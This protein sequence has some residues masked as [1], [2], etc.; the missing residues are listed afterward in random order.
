MPDTAIPALPAFDSTWA[1]FSD[2]YR[3]I[4]RQCRALNTDVFQT[5]LLLAPTLC[6]TGSRA[7]ELFYDSSRFQRHGAA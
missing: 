1:F 7:A 3:F 6:L 4:S 5:R 2:P